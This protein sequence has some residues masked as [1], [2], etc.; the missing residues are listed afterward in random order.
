MQYGFA[1]A[2]R[3]GI[4]RSCQVRLQFI[5]CSLGVCSG[6]NDLALFERAHLALQVIPAE[7]E[8]EQEIMTG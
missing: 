7:R 2:V 6:I 8:T 3:H 4:Q 1:V 5:P